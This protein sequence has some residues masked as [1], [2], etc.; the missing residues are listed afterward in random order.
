MTAANEA[1]SPTLVAPGPAIAP[2][3]AR[4]GEEENRPGANADSLPAG[5][6]SFAGSLLPPTLRT[7]LGNLRRN[8][9][10]SALT[11]L[12][13]I[14]GVGAVIAMTEIGARIQSSD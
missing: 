7:A 6:P 3:T 2:L 4:K 8:K 9:M 1:Q 5:R 12:G 14:I 11:A 13:V 10:R